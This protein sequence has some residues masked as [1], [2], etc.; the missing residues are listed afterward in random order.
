[1]GA[2]ALIAGDWGTTN[3]RLFLCDEDGVQLD[4]ARGPGAAEVGG[5]FAAVFDS[6]TLGWQQQHGTLPTVLC[7]MVGSSIG[8]TQTS[9]VGCPARPAQIAEAC[10]ELR[11]GRIQ[12]VPGLS[13]RNRL[14]A[15]DV[16]RGEETQILGALH[17]EP[18]L[19]EGRHLLCLPG[20]HTK[21]GVLENGAV[22]EFLTAATGELFALIC[23][24]SVL[25]GDGREHAR[26]LSGGASFEEGL[27]EFTRIPHTQLLHRIFE[28]RSRRL[29]GELA[30]G[31]AADY[32]SGLLIAS[33]VSGAVEL[34][35]GV[36]H[37]VC[38]I[39]TR[40]LTALYGTALTRANR[41]TV[42]V[43][44]SAASLAG[45][46]RVHQLLSLQAP[47]HAG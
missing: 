37:T 4:T 16:M 17:L 10:V 46:A 26:A 31:A 39:G 18:R 27:A 6:L 20:T 38:L 40:A 45:L 14:G 5:E 25:V 19:R 7:G 47:S 1:M 43:E 24:H 32:L 23:D 3:L 34:F 36:A 35:A 11:G 15:P 41:E 2:P 29:T 30:T 28:C 22:T 9:Y 21:W 13:C 33:D 42:H 8:W 12:I 44:G